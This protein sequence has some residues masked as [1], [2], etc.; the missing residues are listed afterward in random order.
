MAGASVGLDRPCNRS[1]LSHRQ[2]VVVTRTPIQAMRTFGMEVMWR[3]RVGEGISR[4]FPQR[5]QS[6]FPNLQPSVSTSPP[7]Q[8]PPA[9]QT[10]SRHD[11]TSRRTSRQSVYICARS[12]TSS[13]L[14]KMARNNNN[15]PPAAGQLRR[16]DRVKRKPDLFRKLIDCFDI[17]ISQ[18]TVYKFAQLLQN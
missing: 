15:V 7:S 16:S 18:D 3:Q 1:V 14:E 9:S 5:H 13:V 10:S 8:T 4:Q 6:R 2:T 12:L 17:F 11:V